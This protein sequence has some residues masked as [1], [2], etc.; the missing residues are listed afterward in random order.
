MYICVVYVDRCECEVKFIQEPTQG[1]VTITHVCAD[2]Y[3]KHSTG[4][5][6]VTSA[7]VFSANV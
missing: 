1:K 5:R 4:E 2:M 6:G 7:K 3:D